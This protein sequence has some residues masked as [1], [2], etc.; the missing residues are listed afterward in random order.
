MEIP[1]FRFS[2]PPLKELPEKITHQEILSVFWNTNSKM[3][4]LRQYPGI[5]YYMIGFSSKK[6]FL[7]LFL[8]YEDDKVNFKEVI[9]A[10][11]DAIREGYC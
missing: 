10:D 11:E 8:N 5:H 4:P 3:D 1:D 9:V 6:R 2:F 7:E